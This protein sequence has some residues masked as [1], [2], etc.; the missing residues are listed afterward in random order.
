MH[1]FEFRNRL[2]QVMTVLTLTFSAYAHA[3][4][5]AGGMDATGNGCNG[6]Q[7]EERVAAMKS[8]LLYLQGAAAMANLRLERAKQRQT[9]AAAA[10][11][12]GEVDL[13]A[14]LQAV[15]DAE[16]ADVGATKMVEHRGR[17]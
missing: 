16:K 7:A 15:S 17:K 3:D 14:A 10:V 8:H 1:K 2:I 6:D 5:C 4:S 12:E 13:K 9:E 11:K